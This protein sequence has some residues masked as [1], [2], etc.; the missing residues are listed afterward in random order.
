[1]R[2]VLRPWQPLKYLVHPRARQLHSVERLLGL[3]LSMLVACCGLLAHP[4]VAGS[5]TTCPIPLTY[6]VKGRSIGRSILVSYQLANSRTM[7][8]ENA[9]VRIGLPLTADALVSKASVFPSPRG[10]Q[11]I[12]LNGAI[13]WMNVTIPAKRKRKFSLKLQALACQA[14][15]LE[16]DFLTYLVSENGTSYC[17]SGQASSQVG[18]R[19]GRNDLPL[20]VQLVMISLDPFPRACKCW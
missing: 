2:G 17:P 4:V 5:D 15:T 11:W 8:V 10:M 13:Y 7:N 12:E 19:W 3:V 14:K 6:A 20:L 18:R 1:M 16:F 9:M